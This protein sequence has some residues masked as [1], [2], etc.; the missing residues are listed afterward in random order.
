MSALRPTAD[1]EA[2]PA[3][4]ARIRITG[5]S[6]DA[7]VRALGPIELEFP[8]RQLAVLLGASG[9]GKS[10]LLRLLAGL[11]H[12]DEG[13]V[14]L[15]VEPVAFVFQDAHL[16]PWRTVRQ[17]VAL[18]LELARLERARRAP[19]VQ[20]ALSLVGLEDA[21]ERY[22]A[23]LSG[24][25]RMRASLARALVTRPAM[26][27]LDEPFAALDEISRQRLD[28]L[29]RHLHQTQNL[30]VVFVTHSIAEAVYLSE[31]A[32]VLSK[33]PGRVVLDWSNPLPASRD[34][35]TRASPGFA[36]ACG[37]LFDVLRRSQ[38]ED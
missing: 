20:E 4:A 2:A 22:P 15:D 3:S 14:R 16:L 26:L 33:R 28:D 9:C 6:F 13:E 30:T 34:A 21:A 37:E 31:R 36:A 25:M 32:I 29:L 7:G 1:P 11:E 12:P 24:G 17:N 35:S 18:P 5:K 27:L 38:Q 10:T 23:Q 19:L 8:R